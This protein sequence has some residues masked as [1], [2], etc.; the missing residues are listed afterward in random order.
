MRTCESP[1]VRRGVGHCNRYG[2]PSKYVESLS[3][4]VP[5]ATNLT[6][7]IGVTLQ[8]G[9]NGF[10]IEDGSSEA[11]E[12]CIKKMLNLSLENKQMMRENALKTANQC[13]SSHSSSLLNNLR[14]F[15][16]KVDGD[17]SVNRIYEKK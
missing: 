17:F 14:D 11:I 12:N 10:V 6:S 13:F 8:D 9:F 1:A 16:S 2:F 4:G 5:V 15:L 3:L 7:D